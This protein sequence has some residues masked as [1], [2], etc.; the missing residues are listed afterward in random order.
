MRHLLD[1][2][3]DAPAQEGM[4]RRPSPESASLCRPSYLDLHKARTMLGRTS[5]SL[6][7]PTARTRSESFNVHQS[8]H[9]GLHS[10]ALTGA[11]AT[12]TAPISSHLGSYFPHHRQ[13]STLSL[14][15][16]R[17][18]FSSGQDV[19]FAA[20]TNA[21]LEAK[22]IEDLAKSQRASAWALRGGWHHN[23]VGGKR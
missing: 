21:L 10:A 19:N 13:P 16:T 22:H 6:S 23:G 9:Q 4:L 8:F 3:A 20:V 18:P 14:R 7:P 5:M 15:N 12:P 11:A 17:S 1:R 2:T